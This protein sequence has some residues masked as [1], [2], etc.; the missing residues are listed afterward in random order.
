MYFSK[1]LC[2]ILWHRQRLGP[3]PWVKSQGRCWVSLVQSSPVAQSCPERPHEPQHARPPWWYIGKEFT[4]QCRRHRLD[5]WVRKIP[6]RRKWQ[7]ILVLPGEF[8]GQR[9][10][11]GYI[12]SV[13]P[14]KSRLSQRS[15]LGHYGLQSHNSPLDGKMIHSSPQPRPTQERA[16]QHRRPSNLGPTSQLEGDP[17]PLL[18]P[19]KGRSSF[20][21]EDKEHIFN[22]TSKIWKLASGQI[23]HLFTQIP[24]H[25]GDHPTTPPPPP[26]RSPAAVRGQFQPGGLPLRCNFDRRHQLFPFSEKVPGGW[27]PGAG[28]MW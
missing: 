26:S 27:P 10:L 2:V 17:R 20:H 5:S 8:H 14:Y 22:R 1:P 23:C 24:F 4:C 25:P 12:Q 11:A 21:T 15:C 18:Q 9:S 16:N 19:E 13:V 28:H 3:P 6:W 7:S